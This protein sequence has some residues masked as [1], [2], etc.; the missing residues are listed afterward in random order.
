MYQ[1]TSNQQNQQEFDKFVIRDKKNRGRFSKWNPSYIVAMVNKRIAE[2][3]YALGRDKQYWNPNRPI[4]VQSGITS[5]NIWDCILHIGG[6]TKAQNKWNPTRMT[7]IEY[8]EDGYDKEFRNF[9]QM[10]HALHYGY[11]FSV[12][13]SCLGVFHFL[14]VRWIMN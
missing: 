5:S 4:V 8:P 2:R 7:M 13:F 12:C 10:I 14:F 3:V 11:G 6:G 9:V 1:I